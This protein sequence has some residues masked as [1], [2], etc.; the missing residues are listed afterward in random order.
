M[1]PTRALLGWLA[2]PVLSGLALL[3]AACATPTGNFCCLGYTT[4][5]NYDPNIRTVRV[6][7]F[8]NRTYRQ[9]LEFDLTRELCH[10]VARDTPFRVVNGD[11]EPA[12]TELCGT[13][14]NL[15]K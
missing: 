2:V 5:P 6:P 10:A 13:I 8:K 14:I 7:I 3:A 15:T 1:R 12:D 11:C 4:A 9:A